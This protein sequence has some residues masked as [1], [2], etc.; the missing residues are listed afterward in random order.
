M[1]DRSLAE[2]RRVEAVRAAELSGPSA[3][4]MRAALH[5]LVWSDRHPLSVRTAAM[6]RLIA[7]DP[8]GFWVAAERWL[9]TV[10]R[11]EMVEAIG[12][13]AIGADRDGLPALF[14]RR[15][16]RSA[17]AV[18]EES[19]PE[20]HV[21]E[22]L[23]GGRSAETVLL[24]LLASPATA[25][26]DAAAAWTVGRRW[27]GEA[28]GEDLLN[29]GPPKVS[30]LAM[31]LRTA[32]QRVDVLPAEIEGLRWLAAL[33]ADTTEWAA[34]EKL[35]PT[36]HPDAAGT[37]G[38]RHLPALAAMPAE[39][40]T[41]TR[42]ALA[43][44]LDRQLVGAERVPRE[45]PAG[46][47]VHEVSSLNWADLAVTL[48]V[49]EAMDEP[50]VVA[51]WFAQADAD[52]ADENSEH[53]GVLGWDD[54]GR[55]AATGFPPE[56]RQGDRKFFSPP[57]L[58][59]RLYVGLAHYHFHAQDFDNAE[60]AGPGRGDLAFTEAMRANTLTLTFVDRDRLNVDLA[61]PGAG[62]RVMDL[63]CVRRGR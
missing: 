57:A 35:R 42:D 28:W 38:L 53:G 2:S 24:D 29:D 41:W 22:R 26:P 32:A 25:W 14:V 55:W 47:A 40:R 20:R 16:A 27:R 52:H 9:G 18:V 46:V 51:A 12:G 3:D 36:L 43:A 30:G 62:G 23:S 56:R 13:R 19:R 45:L 7:D 48:A 39:R 59:E 34:Y 49:R 37:V 58:I 1:L 17:A 60:F 11:L 8:A 31:Q 4:E 21:V 44:H 5:V 54:A 6:D 15:W 61:L 50:A 10:D 63:G 33:W